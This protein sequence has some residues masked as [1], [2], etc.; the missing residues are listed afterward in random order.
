MVSLFHNAKNLFV[1]IPKR[2]PSF[3]IAV[4]NL[5]LHNSLWQKRWYLQ[6]SKGFS[7]HDEN[8]VSWTAGISN[9]VR[10][11]Q[12]EKAIGLFKT[13]LMSEQK[14]NYVTVLSVLRAIGQM[15]SPNTAK[16]IHALA[17]KSGFDSEVSVVTAVVGVYS[18]CKMEGV[19]KLFDQT[20]N[21]DVVLWSAMVSACV[22]N[23][24]YVEALEFLRKMQIC[25]VQPNHVS[26]VT[27]L[28]A[29]ANLG[30]LLL[31]KE[32]HGFSIKRVFYSHINVQNSLVDM[33]A[34]CRNFN[35]SVLV[36]RRMQKK[37]LISWRSM[38]C[39]CV[40]NECPEKTLVLFSQMRSRGIEFDVSIIRELV[41]A[42][43]QLKEIKEGVSLHGLVL[44][45]G[46]IEIVSMATALLQMY[47]E[48]GEVRSAGILFDYLKKK[49]LIAWSAM[50]S[51]YVKNEQPLNAFQVYR[52]MLSAGEKPN[53]V[54]FVSLL[55]SCSS[56]AVQE[57]GESIH[58]HLT[59]AGFM[60][61]A[62]L[63][64]ALIDLYCKFGRTRQ[65]KAL[66]DENPTRDLICWSSM[67]NGYGI[68][69]FGEEALECF[70]NMLHCGITPNDV[71]F[72]SV[73]AACSH[74]GLEYEGWNWFYAME[75]K[76][77]LTPKLAHYACMVDILGRQGNV[78]EAF[79]FVNNMP[80]DPDKRIWGAILAGCRQTCGSPE[81]SEI[82]AR[83]LLSLDP[84]NASYHVILSNLYA[85]QGRW[86]DV[87]RLR[88]LVDSR[89]LKKE[90]GYSMI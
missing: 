63:T 31:G 77:G 41:V 46:Y 62:F 89:G 30:A 58:A 16:I 17:V 53:E 5:F 73:L 15:V 38:I 25:G 23:E 78:E 61:N 68:N 32:I 35:Y 51:A 26:I 65:G 70:S 49:D 36:F 74:C 34:K 7:L 19:R 71:V 88:E 37:D 22:K 1:K 57:I 42:S 55:Q 39:G 75:E 45:L 54:T 18:G 69:G 20:L 83:Q 24:E 8:V 9:L 44:K 43:S 66:F 59:K 4:N 11:N 72:I 67:I 79:E 21:K 47:A 48:F 80:I 27:I 3:H 40:E 56:M 76:Y 29:C 50:I 82:A 81:I 52:Q 6:G 28:P 33:Y 10:Q 64:S 60:S 13:M 90:I 86:N 85:E 84:K 12:P 2:T 87:A 14:P